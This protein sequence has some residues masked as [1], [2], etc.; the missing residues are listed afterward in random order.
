MPFH[1]SVSRAA[2]PWILVLGVGATG[3]GLLDVQTQTQITE[4]ALQNSTNAALIV[5]G[6]VSDFEC[7]LGA[8]VVGMGLLS[9]EFEAA[10]GFAV[11]WDWDRRTMDPASGTYALGDCL[12]NQVTM[13]TY[14]PVSTAR[15]TAD[16]SLALLNGWTDAEVP[17]RIGLIALAQAY[18]GYSRILLGEGFC[19]AAIDGGPELTPAQVFQQ[20]E[21]KF[22][23]AIA[24]AGS[25]ARPELVLMARVGRARARLNQAKLADAA[26]DAALVPVSFVWNANYNATAVRS[27]NQVTNMHF[28]TNSIIVSAPFRNLS[29]DGV[30]DPRLKVVDTGLNSLDATRRLWLTSK[31]PLQNSP[32]PLATGVEAQLILAEAQGGAQA[33]TIINNLHVRV[34]LPATFASTDP[35]VIKNQIIDERRRELFVDGHRSYDVLRYDVPL[36]PPPGAVHPHGGAYGNQKC[37]PLPNVERDNNPNLRRGS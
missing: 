25:A 18:G 35:A 17:G 22:T 27:Q 12:P 9:D 23:E 31:Y 34:G 4:A 30:P 7:A 1:S 15:Y 28:R 20:A 10:G 29:F 21:A 3:C 13:G 26:Q 37:L 33:V 2:R 16:N 14:R 36:V 8:Y 5:N 11:F 32:I 19:S 24:S 6:A